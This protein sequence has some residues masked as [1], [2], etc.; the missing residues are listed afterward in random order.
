[1]TLRSY[2]SSASE[3]AWYAVPEGNAMSGLDAAKKFFRQAA[4]S[5]SALDSAIALMTNVTD[6]ARVRPENVLLL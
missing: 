5:I 2:S 6:C 4:N 3:S 1:M